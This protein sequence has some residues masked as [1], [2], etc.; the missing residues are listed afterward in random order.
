LQDFYTREQHNG[1]WYGL[2]Q[3]LFYKVSDCMTY[4]IRAE[5]FRDRTAPAWAVLGQHAPAV[6]AG[7]RVGLA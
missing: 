5:W 4:G 7:S 3:Y 2:N 6:S 1:K